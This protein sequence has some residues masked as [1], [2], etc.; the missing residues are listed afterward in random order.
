MGLADLGRARRTRQSACSQCCFAAYRRQLGEGGDP[1][2]QL[3][4]RVARPGRPRAGLRSRHR[5]CGRGSR[6]RGRSGD[7]DSPALRRA[8]DR[9]VRRRVETHRG[10]GTRRRVRRG[11]TVTGL[12]GH[13][14][15]SHRRTWCHGRLRQCRRIDLGAERAVP[16]P[17]RQVR[18]FRRHY[19]VQHV[20]RCALGVPQHDQ[21]ALLHARQPKQSGTAHRTRCERVHRSG[22][23][24]PLRPRRRRR[25][26]TQT[27]RTGSLRQDRATTSTS[28]FGG[29][30]RAER[31][32]ARRNR[33]Q[34]SPR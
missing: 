26:R 13:G 8:R 19:R 33:S 3:P 1:A 23:R 22:D 18:V 10:V 15:R 12:V 25:R 30:G 14:A 28:D 11:L 17:S 4:D 27:R 29:L 2:S 16:C 9:S 21:P 32:R 20:V 24:Q 7:P 6:R 34:C 5:A 31:N